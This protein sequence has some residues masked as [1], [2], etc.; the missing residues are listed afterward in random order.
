MSCTEVMYQAYYPYL[1]QRSSG[2][3]APPTRAPHHHFAPFTQYD[4]VSQNS[5]LIKLSL[6]YIHPYDCRVTAG[7]YLRTPSIPYLGV[8]VFVEIIPPNV[9]M[10][11][12]RK[13]WAG[14]QTFHTNAQ[15]LILTFFNK[16]FAF[17]PINLSFIIYIPIYVCICLSIVNFFMHINIIF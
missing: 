4:R 15:L 12:L 16:Y 9:P 8:V 10:P 2:T 7:L 1:Y 14:G 17:H 13:F 6:N 3:A 11:G 5:C